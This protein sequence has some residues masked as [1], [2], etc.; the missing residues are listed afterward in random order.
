MGADN[1]GRGSPRGRGQPPDPL[2]GVRLARRIRAALR[3]PRGCALPRCCRAG[4]SRPPRRP[5]R[6]GRGRSRGLLDGGLGGPARADAARRRRDRGDAALDNDSGPSRA[7]MGLRASLPGDALRLAARP[8][9]G[10]RAACRRVR[11]TGDQLCHDAALLSWR[12]RRGRRGTAR[13][14]RRAGDERRASPNSAPR[15]TDRG[16]ATP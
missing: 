14:L 5:P 1:Y 9:R 12:N 8:R 7:R 4:D 15:K 6:R 3:D 16:S 2:Q 13:S 10:C 11:A